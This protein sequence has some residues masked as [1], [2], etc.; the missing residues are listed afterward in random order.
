MH[1]KAGHEITYETT[2][3]DDKGKFI[4]A[5]QVTYRYK[6]PKS[7]G[8]FNK[9]IDEYCTFEYANITNT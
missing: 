3:Q 9:I 4:K 7:Q 8:T 6:V 1:R 2:E 5:A